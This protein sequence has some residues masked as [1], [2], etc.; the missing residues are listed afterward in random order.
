MMWV[1]WTLPRL[2]IDQVMT[3]CLKYCVPLAAMCFLGT[4]FW[5]GLGLPTTGE[6]LGLGTHR[7]A[8]SVREEWVV[9][10]LSSAPAG[11]A[12]GA[13]S[14][15]VCAGEGA[16]VKWGVRA[17]SKRADEYIMLVCKEARSLAGLEHPGSVRAQD[18]GQRK[19]GTPVLTMDLVSG[20][21]LHDLAQT[22]NRFELI[23]HALDQILGALAHAHARGII[24]GDLKPSNVLVEEVPGHPPKIHILD[25]GL[26]WLKQDPHDE[27]LDL[28][29]IHISEPTRPY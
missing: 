17:E 29:L 12:V 14:L 10:D 28:S 7:P 16:H 19:D 8:Y 22:A 9:R 1:R 4:L 27:R 11:A 2:R 18:F 13:V 3:T 20:V 5:Q 24:H 15:N 25:F 6:L 21:S 23:W 26:A